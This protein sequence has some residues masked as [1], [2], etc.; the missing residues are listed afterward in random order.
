ML[1][2]NLALLILSI[3]IAGCSATGP[4]HADVTVNQQALIDKSRITVY[5]TGGHFQYSGRAVRLKLDEKVLGKVDYKGF[6]VFDITAGQHTLTADMW[7]S[8]GKCDVA[9]DLLPSTEYYFE[10]QP[11]FGNLASG[12][13]GGALGMAI[14]SGGKVCGGAFA[15]TPVARDSALTDLQPLRMTK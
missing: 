7:D 10:V 8:P 4:L 12:L 15:I 5:R 14:E 3:T 13:V 6:N 2:R 1:I 9:L 11:R